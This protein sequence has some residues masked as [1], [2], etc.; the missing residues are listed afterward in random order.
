M[1]KTLRLVLGSWILILGWYVITQ[2]RNI[3]QWQE[4]FLQTSPVDPRD[5]FRWD[6]VILWYEIQNQKCDASEQE[7]YSMRD[8]TWRWKVVYI[9]LEKDNQAVAR[10]TWCQTTRPDSWLFIKWY[11]KYGS[12]N[13]G[14][15]K[16]FVQEWS[17]LELENHVWDMYMRTRITKNWT[18]RIKWHELAIE[19]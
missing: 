12:I 2:E 8:L 3:A 1:N 16:Y 18:V 4:V 10:A 11:E 5:F 9:T 17:W 6:Y 15:E 13:F 14:I 19:M 7:W